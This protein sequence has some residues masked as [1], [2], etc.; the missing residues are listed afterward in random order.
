ILQHG[1][2]EGILTGGNLTLI[3]SSLGTPW[4]IDTRG[5]I[6]F[7]EEI[8]EDAYRIDRMLLQLKLSRKLTTAAG[9]LLGNFSP[10]NLDTIKLALGELVVPEEKPIVG[11]LPCGHC[12]P[13]LT[14]PLGQMVRITTE[15]LHPVQIC[16]H[17]GTGAEHTPLC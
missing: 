4:E 12:M 5:K 11:G 16:D 17:F 3:V 7:I 13:N 10:E 2:A 15:S 8:G 6:L 1:Y 14:L 9:F